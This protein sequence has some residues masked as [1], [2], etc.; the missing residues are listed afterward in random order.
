MVGAQERM[1]RVESRRML[2]HDHA[3]SSVFPC[4]SRL[5]L[6][7]G[8]PARIGGSRKILMRRN[9]ERKTWRGKEAKDAFHKFLG[10]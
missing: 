2:L 1:A 6:A 10:D 5:G 3:Q 4:E 9:R 8:T 7:A